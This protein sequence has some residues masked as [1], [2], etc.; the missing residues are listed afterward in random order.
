VL[1]RYQQKMCSTPEQ[2][3]HTVIL[4]NGYIKKIDVKTSLYN[5]FTAMRP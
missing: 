1:N 4:I 5:L 3:I 2:E